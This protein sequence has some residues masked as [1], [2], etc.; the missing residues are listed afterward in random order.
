[1]E[2]LI[3]CLLS[4]LTIHHWFRPEQGV[5]GGRRS[6]VAAG[7]ALGALSMT[8]PEGAALA[9][10]LLAS[11]RWAR[12]GLADTLTTLGV[13]GVG[14]VAPV[15]VSLLTVGTPLPTT[16]AGRRW[17]HGYSEMSEPAILVGF[18]RSW[19][20]Q[21]GQFSLGPG[22]RLLVLFVLLGLVGLFAR[23][24]HRRRRV[25]VL[26][27]WAGLHLV[28]YAIALPDTGHGGRYQ[29]F[30]LAL[31][32]P[33][34]A[35]GALESASAIASRLRARW[36]QLALPAVALSP[37]VGFA[38]LSLGIWSRIL[39][40]GVDHINGTHR[41]MGEWIRGHLP[42]DAPVAAFDI[43]AMAY[44]SER[45]LIDLGGLVDRSY[46]PYLESGRVPEYLE[47]RGDR[48]VVIPL[49]RDE[50][51][52]SH[53]L[54]RRLGLLDDPALPLAKV[55]EVESDDDDAWALGFD[56]TGH[57]A[58]RQVLYAIGSR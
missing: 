27:L 46:V 41:R 13:A 28:L 9:L 23:F 6:A 37:V 4:V 56:A 38:V 49:G 53:E 11:V 34:V 42:E 16:F 40:V 51:A 1:M 2:P 22:R 48:Y 7:V 3:L 15:I 20:A 10:L 32:F 29:P 33:L 55:H 44:F 36:A 30:T 35:L 26:C 43:G 57:A 24:R 50:G 19:V 52:A 12:R 14:V 31:F 54:G 17:I 5:G 25:F 45:P 8:R 58:P 39:P 18:L 47:S 21:L